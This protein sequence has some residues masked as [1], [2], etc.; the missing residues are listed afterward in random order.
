MSQDNTGQ[1]PHFGEQEEQE[2][3]YVADGSTEEGSDADQDAP[4]QSAAGAKPINPDLHGAAREVTEN[5]S[6]HGA[7]ETPGA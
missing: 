1:E 4:T 7:A 5:A 3:F 2:P 6:G